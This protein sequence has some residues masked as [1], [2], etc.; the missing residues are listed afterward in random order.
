[1]LVLIIIDYKNMCKDTNFIDLKKYFSYI[2]L[3]IGKSF[4]LGNVL[5][6]CIFLNVGKLSSTLKNNS[7]LK[8]E[9]FF[10]LVEFSV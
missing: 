10:N 5:I 2:F 9:Y 6:F 3:D 8:A 1:M 4:L 7:R